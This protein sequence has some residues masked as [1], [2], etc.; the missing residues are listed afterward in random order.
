MQQPDFPD[1]ARVRPL[2]LLA[3][4]AASLWILTGALFKLL[5]GSPALLPAF[6]HE[7]PISVELI[8]PVVIG[9]ELAVVS[10]AL[11]RPRFGWGLVALQYLAFFGVL[12]IQIARG[13]E[14]CGCMGGNVT[15]APITM[16]AIDGVIFAALL[17]T[18]PWSGLGR[19]GLPLPIAAVAALAALVAPNFVGRG[20]SVDLEAVR[21]RLAS[22]DGTAGTA[23]GAPGSSGAAGGGSSSNAASGPATGVVAGGGDAAATAGA[24]DGATPASGSSGEGAGDATDGSA[25]DGAAPQPGTDDGAPA[26]VAQEQP[27]QPVTPP[28]P[29]EEESLGWQIF[30]VEDWV[31]MDVFETDLAAYLDLAML[32]LDGTW[33]FYRTTCDHCAEHMIDLMNAPPGKP[34][35]LIRIPEPGDNEDNRVV[36]L[37]PA[38]VQVELPAIVEYVLTTPADMEVEGGIV[39]GAREGIL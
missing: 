29:V 8:Y 5:E 32:P 2:A 26:E 39:A 36:H 24:G 22:M 34:L 15:I 1:T 23:A 11:L 16:L 20:Q 37:M 9:V 7:L 13:E 33:V 17:A 28:E 14:S 30:D 21:E 4:A 10:L 27:E 25:T 19:F 38:G 12:G 18:R 31:G 6:M 3:L 35:A